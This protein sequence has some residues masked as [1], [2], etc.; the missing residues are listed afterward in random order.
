[1]CV[2]VRDC[3]RVRVMLEIMSGVTDDIFA[4]HLLGGTGETGEAGGGCA[5]RVRARAASN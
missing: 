2:R 3:V 1:M 4:I 5:L